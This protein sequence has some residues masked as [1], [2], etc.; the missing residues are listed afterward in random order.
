ML[1]HRYFKQTET[2]DPGRG[3][4]EADY[5]THELDVSHGE[6]MN[7]IGKVGNSLPA[8]SLVWRPLKNQAR[9]ENAA[10]PHPKCSSSRSPRIVCQGYSGKSRKPPSRQRA[11]RNAQES[12]SGGYC[13]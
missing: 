9:H 11:S 4:W 5:W 1:K 13:V 12:S 6:L 3:A 10:S 8:E 7:I 2:P